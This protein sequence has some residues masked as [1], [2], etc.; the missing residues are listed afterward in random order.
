[1]PGLGEEFKGKN[2]EFEPKKSAIM[3]NILMVF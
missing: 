2:L 1:V 3:T